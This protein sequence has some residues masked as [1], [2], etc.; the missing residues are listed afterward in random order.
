[1]VMSTFVKRALIASTAAAAAALV[2]AVPAAA[3]PSI[4]CADG[5]VCVAFPKG[6]FLSVPEGQ[7]QQFPGGVTMTEIVN[8][9]KTSY[10][11]GG[12]PNFGLAPGD[13]IFRDQTIFGFGPGRVCLS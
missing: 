11:V 6:A 3:A 4:P 8:R 1:M 5:Y 13:D 2:P 9:T 12:S 10:C 7:S